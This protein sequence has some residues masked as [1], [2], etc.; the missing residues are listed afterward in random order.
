MPA[1]QVS[2]IPAPNPP[3]DS[4]PN[5]P[6]RRFKEPRALEA[7]FDPGCAHS[8]PFTPL[9]SRASSVDS[10]PGAARSSASFSNAGVSAELGFTRRQSM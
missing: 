7:F 9:F 8:T 4:P 10:G 6:P 1:S 5:P 2:C 3:A